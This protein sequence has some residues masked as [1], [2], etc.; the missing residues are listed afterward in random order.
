MNLRHNQY[1]PIPTA[2]KPPFLQTHRCAFT[3]RNHH[4][5]KYGATGVFRVR[6]GK[7]WG[8]FNAD[9]GRYSTTINRRQVY[10]PP[11]GR[12]KGINK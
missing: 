5:I 1:R 10:P 2:P 9:G 6:P 3:E 11:P 4:D 8:Y 12:F 7:L